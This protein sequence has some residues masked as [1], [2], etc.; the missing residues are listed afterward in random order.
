MTLCQTRANMV[1]VQSFLC[2]DLTHLIPPILT[3][4]RVCAKR[5]DKVYYPP[6]FRLLLLRQTV[7]EH[8]N[9]FNQRTPTMCEVGHVSVF[10]A[11]RCVEGLHKRQAMP[12]LAWRFFSGQ[13]NN[14]KLR[15]NCVKY[16]A[17]YNS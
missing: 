14:I 6:L 1:Y 16:S 8:T 13:Q 9:P 5:S 4:V 15:Q 11:E 2:N 12:T 10:G 3:Y 7:C 17:R